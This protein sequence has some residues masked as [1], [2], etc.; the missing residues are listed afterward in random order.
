[1][2]LVNRPKVETI[3]KHGASWRITLPKV[4]C[5]RL[6]WNLGD[7]V[8]FTVVGTSLVMTKVDLPKVGDIRN[9]TPQG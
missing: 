1:M 6:G 5:A 3:K 7:V 9:A 4:Q 8:V 2:T